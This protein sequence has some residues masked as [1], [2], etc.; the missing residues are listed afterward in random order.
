MAAIT[1]LVCTAGGGTPTLDGSSSTGLLCKGGTHH[2]KEVDPNSV[3]AGDGADGREDQQ[4]DGPRQGLQ[5][6]KSTSDS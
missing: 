6:R 4:A 2:G 5:G 3:R 1:K